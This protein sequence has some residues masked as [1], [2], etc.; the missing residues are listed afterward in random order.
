VTRT[1]QDAAD[2]DRATEIEAMGQKVLDLTPAEWRTIS[3]A[4]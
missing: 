3:T 4:E 2:Y 1:A